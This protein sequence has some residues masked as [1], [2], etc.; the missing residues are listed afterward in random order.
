[1]GLDWKRLS[2]RVGPPVIVTGLVVTLLMFSAVRGGHEFGSISDSRSA[3]ANQ[4]A[5]NNSTADTTT[6][7]AFEATE[8]AVFFSVGNQLVGIPLS[9]TGTG[10]G[11]AHQLIELPEEPNFIV[12]TPGGV[13]LFVGFN[14]I[15]QIYVYS[16]EDFSLQA[17]IPTEIANPEA[18][19]FSPTGEQ[20]FIFWDQGRK[21]T[22]FSHSRLTLNY[23]GTRE[24]N[25]GED[26]FIAN[27]RGTRLFRAEQQGVR[28][29]L[30]QQLVDADFWETPVSVPVF[31]PG[32]T[33]V[34]GVGQDSTVQVIDERTGR[35][36]R[37]F[38]YPVT[39]QPGVVTD[40]ISFLSTDGTQIF[41]YSPRR[42]NEPRIISSP[43]PIA[44]LTRGAGQSLLAIGAQGSIY[45]ISQ[46]G[47]IEEVTLDLNLN[48]SLADNS[49]IALVATAI[50][51]QDGSFACF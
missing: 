16:A 23:V 50:I 12:P 43:E 25:P 35:I 36:I 1:M 29:H 31:D 32:Y 28:V 26:R 30:A 34:W 7:R 5:G 10:L 2:E 37:R 42:S 48:H 22:E 6:E 13:S 41:Q 3:Q 15:S 24:L 8:G 27:R 19:S 51:R 45:S 33:E 44:F 49:S 4:P 21:V 47:R 40:R 14:G 39:P 9:T 46:T 38:R 18:L 11:I 17:R 20:A